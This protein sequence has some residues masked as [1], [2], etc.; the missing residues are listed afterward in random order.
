MTLL[1][2]PKN[3]ECTVCKAPHLTLAREITE[4]RTTINVDGDWVAG[5]VNNVMDGSCAPDEDQVRLFCVACG[6]YYE[7]PESLQ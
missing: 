3:N 1:P 6:T 5:P 4:Y 2:T 7:V